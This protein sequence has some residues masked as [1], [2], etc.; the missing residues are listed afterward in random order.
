MVMWYVNTIYSGTDC[1]QVAIENKYFL[2]NLHLDVNQQKWGLYWV[3]QVI[4]VNYPI[5]TVLAVF[6]NFLGKIRVWE[7]SAFKI[8]F[9]LVGFITIWLIYLFSI[10]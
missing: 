2:P 3:D 4:G 10:E 6:K 7:I 5:L 1:R 8:K 9:D